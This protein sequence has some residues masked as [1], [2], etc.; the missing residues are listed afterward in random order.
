MLLFF[1]TPRAAWPKVRASAPYPLALPLRTKM[2]AL[3]EPG[4][5]LYISLC[6]ALGGK[7]ASFGHDVKHSTM[8]GSRNSQQQKH[9]AHKSTLVG[10]LRNL[11]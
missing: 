10:L 9:P 1:V 8:E 4:G 3:A 5:Y 11:D 2:T 7:H 6:T